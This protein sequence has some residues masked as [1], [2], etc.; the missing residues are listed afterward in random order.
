[1]LYFTLVGYSN[2]TERAEPYIKTAKIK[3]QCN[4][5]IKKY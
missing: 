2:V 5:K 4:L 3:D 1:M